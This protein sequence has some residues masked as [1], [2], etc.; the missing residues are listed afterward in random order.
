VILIKYLNPLISRSLLAFLEL[1]IL[2]KS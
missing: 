1:K 2:I